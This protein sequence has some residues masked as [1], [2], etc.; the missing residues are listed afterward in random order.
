MCA[1]S[2]ELGEVTNLGR[3]FHDEADVL[4]AL[5]AWAREDGEPDV[6]VFAAAN[7]NGRTPA[8]I[9]R[10]LLAGE[11][12]DTGFDV[13]AWLFP[14]LQGG[15]SA[16]TD[17]RPRQKVGE[18]TPR[19]DSPPVVLLRQTI[20]YDDADR[21][22]VADPRDIGRALA[23]VMLADGVIHPD[24]RRFLDTVMEQLGAPPLAEQDLRV[25]RP[26]ELGPIADPV[27]LLRA[28][29]RLALADQE[30][31][32]SERRVIAEYARSWRVPL[33]ADPLPDPR[34]IPRLLRALHGLVLR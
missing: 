34:P 5:S 4:D 26:P 12:V 18:A 23:S 21:A 6:G 28:M 25:W 17:E 27:T 10:A 30:A 3:P 31:D 15:G 13:I 32:D 1:Y 2:T 16:A 29:R 22:P 33:P 8:A 9:A 7:F 11:R 14:S 20:S 24:E 19:S